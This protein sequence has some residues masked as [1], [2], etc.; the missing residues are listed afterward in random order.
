[1]ASAKVAVTMDQKLLHEIDRW[2]AS[3][4]FPTRS[5]VI[6]EALSKMRQQRGRRGRLLRELAKLDPAEEQALSEEVF[7]SEVAWPEY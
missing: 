4:E 1:M 2:V 6:Q 7:S 3:G 5:R